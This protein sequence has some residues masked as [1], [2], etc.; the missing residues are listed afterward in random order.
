MSN[1]RDDKDR[2]QHNKN[3]EFSEAVVAPSEEIGEMHF[4]TENY[5]TAIEYFQRALDSQDLRNFPDRYRLHLRISDC[6]RQKGRHREAQARH[7]CAQESGAG[8]QRAGKRDHQAGA[9]HEVQVEGKEPADDRYE[10]HSATETGDHRNDAEQKRD[11]KEQ[12]RPDPPLQGGDGSAL[13]VG[14]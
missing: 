9:A 14:P 3:N 7:S 6:H 4:S 1:A 10:E 13:R 11:D 5:T 12:Q 8:G 2:L